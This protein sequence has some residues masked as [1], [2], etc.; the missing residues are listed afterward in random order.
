MVLTLIRAL[1][2]EFLPQE[3]GLSVAYD[4]Y[5]PQKLLYTK[6]GE[7]SKRSFDLTNIEKL[8]Q[9]NL[10]ESRYNGRE[11]DN[12]VI[13]NFDIDD[14]FIVNLHSRKLPHDKDYHKIHITVALVEKP[15]L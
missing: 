11:I 13:E 10:F 9:D 6:K 2:T 8:L 15:F 14:K 5:F 1:K 4:F 7:I 12:I 3:H